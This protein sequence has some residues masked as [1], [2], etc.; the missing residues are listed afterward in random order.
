[1]SQ[2]NIDTNLNS[3]PIPLPPSTIIPE[4]PLNNAQSIPPPHDTTSIP[5][6]DSTTT[7]LS[8]Q[9]ESETLQKFQDKIPFR[10]YLEHGY[11]NYRTWLSMTLGSPYAMHLNFCVARSINMAKKYAMGIDLE[12]RYI[13]KRLENL[14]G[15]YQMK[16]YENVIQKTLK[17]NLN[18]S[19]AHANSI[20]HSYFRNPKSFDLTLSDAEFNSRLKN[21]PT[22]E[23]DSFSFQTWRNSN[24]MKLNERAYPVTRE[25]I[26][27]G[28][29][30]APPSS[31]HLGLQMFELHGYLPPLINPRVPKKYGV[32]FL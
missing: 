19:D 10:S 32:T 1:M 30:L 17:E 28:E 7:P 9:L 12:I 8:I 29:A 14:F 22:H 21:V 24:H 25:D 27:N 2:N 3:L 15:E 13:I 5:T 4:E 11:K 23:L 26:L 18:L 20:I 31:R 16:N 6:H